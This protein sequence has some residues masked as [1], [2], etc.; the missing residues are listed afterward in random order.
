MRTH[1]K[2]ADSWTKLLLLTMSNGSC[3][4]TRIHAISFMSETF[5]KGVITPRKISCESL[6]K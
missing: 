5:L 1:A 3:H 6:R 2:L 4:H